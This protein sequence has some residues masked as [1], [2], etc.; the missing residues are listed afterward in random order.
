MSSPQNFIPGIYNY[1]DYIC[2]KCVFTNRCYLYWSE[3]DP[4]AADEEIELSATD[5]EEFMDEFDENVFRNPDPADALEDFEPPGRYHRTH[6]V[7]APAYEI[8][9]ILDPIMENLAASN[10]YPEEMTKAIELVLENYL[11]ISVKYYRAIHN[12]SFD[13]GVHISE[14]EVFKYMDAEKILMAVKAFLW[15]LRSGIAT[16]RAF[17]PGYNTEFTQALQLSH[18]I[19]ERIDTDFLPATRIILSRH[20]HYFDDEDLEP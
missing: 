6:G 9:E 1:C 11:L 7:V 3:N 2:E 10:R 8:I 16:L 5:L 4:E 18:E 13:T 19:E 12:I 15:N 17:M 20:S 14:M